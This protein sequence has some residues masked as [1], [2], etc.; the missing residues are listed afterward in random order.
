M[1]SLHLLSIVLL[2]SPVENQLALVIFFFFYISP[3]KSF[4]QVLIPGAKLDGHRGTW[5]GCLSARH[6]M[7]D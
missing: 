1:E 7:Q 6:A 2:T 3:L 4:N 5:T